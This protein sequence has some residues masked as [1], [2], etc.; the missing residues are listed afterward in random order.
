MDIP[1]NSDSIP[2]SY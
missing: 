1:G 2:F